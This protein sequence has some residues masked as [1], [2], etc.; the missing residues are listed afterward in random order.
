MDEA[1]T[2]GDVAAEKG[3]PEPGGELM[4]FD[5]GSMTADKAQSS[6]MSLIINYADPS[7]AA[8]TAVLGLGLVVLPFLS[9][10]NKLSSEETFRYRAHSEMNSKQPMRIFT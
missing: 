5:D 8:G 10:L 1:E 9:K 3:K 4:L 7:L 2:G 6:A